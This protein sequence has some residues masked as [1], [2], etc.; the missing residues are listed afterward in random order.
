MAGLWQGECSAQS[1]LPPKSYE[2][3]AHL[4]AATGFRCIWNRVFDLNPDPDVYDL[5][6]VGVADTGVVDFENLDDS[7]VSGVFNRDFYYVCDIAMEGGVVDSP[8]LD[9]LYQEG[10]NPN[11]EPGYSGKGLG[12]KIVLTVATVDSNDPAVPADDTE[13]NLA[14]VKINQASLVHIPAIGNFIVGGAPKVEYHF[15]RIGIGLTFGDDLVTGKY[16]ILGAL[17]GLEPAEPF[18]NADR[19]GDY[20]GTLIITMTTNGQQ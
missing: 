8:S 7:L 20:T 11:S 4:P 2:V 13:N 19:S 16:N 10:E 14:K 17:K 9:F 5:E 15:P 3:R 1:Q 6:F 18:T 12:H